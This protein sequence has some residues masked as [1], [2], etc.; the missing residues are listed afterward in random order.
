GSRRSGRGG[1]AKTTRCSDL[2][3]RGAGAAGGA[4]AKGRKARVRNQTLGDRLFNAAVYAIATAFTLFCF[5]PFYTMVIASV[6]E[7]HALISNGYQLWPAAFSLEAFQWVLRGQQVVKS[8]AITVFVTLVSTALSLML[9]CAL[10]Y[11]MSDRKFKLR[12]PIS[13]YVYFT[14]IFSG[15]I[16]PRYITMRTVGLYDHV[17]APVVPLLMKPWWIFILR[18]YLHNLP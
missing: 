1:E 15:G 4:A 10:A 18:H 14:M 8:Y 16:I 5:L 2:G 3:P 13:F 6:T 9:M 17:L 12:N 7:K 11:A